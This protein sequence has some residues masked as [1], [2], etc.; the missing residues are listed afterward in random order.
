[1]G[2]AARPPAWRALAR[3]GPFRWDD[4]EPYRAARVALGVALP[5]AGGWLTGHLE[6]GAYAALGALPAG[7]A[8]FQGE[9]RTRL[10]AV[11]VASA[12]MA[13]STFVGATAAFWAPWMLVPILALWGYVTGLSESLGQ[14]FS[15]AIL[16][17]PMALLIAVGLPAPYA[18]AGLYA[19][20]V[21]A[22]GALQAGLVAV[23][24]T[25]RPGARERAM[26]AASFQGLATYA[27]RVAEGVIG[28][29]PPTAFPAGSIL[30]DPN[31]LLPSALRLD[32]VDLLE[33][34]ERIRASLAALEAHAA[35]GLPE[36]THAIGSLM[37]KAAAV[38][39]LIA[40]A[41][42]GPASGRVKAVRDINE[43]AASLV[44]AH[45]V[46][47]RWAGEALLGQLRAVGRVVTHLETLNAPSPADGARMTASPASVP[48]A[49][50]P[51]L[52]LLRANIT[53]KTETGRHAI[54]L[55]VTVALAEILALAAGLYESR[56][57]A[58]TIF[59]VLKP[60]YN[61]TLVRGVHRALGTIAGAALGVA[62]AAAAHHTLGL[63]V[64]DASVLIYLAYTLFDANYLFFS[65]FLTAFIVIILALF[66]VPAVPTAEARILNTGIGA[67]MALGAYL[68]W[69]T[70]E[71]M[72]AQEK[73]ARLIETHGL[74]VTALLRTLTDPAQRDAPALRALQATARR[75]RSDAEAAC[76]RLAGE[77]A[78]PPLTPE[79]ALALIAALAREARAALALHAFVLAESAS[80]SWAG[81]PGDTAALDRFTLARDRAMHTLAHSVRTLHAPPP[82]TALRPLYVGLRDLG[83][84]RLS[85]LL[86]IA[87]RLVNTT[88]S[89]DTILRERLPASPRA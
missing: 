45:D 56:W 60:D 46:P 23:A 59:F 14:R 70:W 81:I 77:P 58:L 25:L 21:L 65:L 33:Q 8:S 83:P 67:I 27:A 7:F 29:P 62:A 87:D 63:L 16:Q 11:A 28:P 10:A 5:L 31:P 12:G 13:I 18:Q 84:P 51:G 2:A 37:Q 35:D 1:M 73:F 4:V 78:H 86:D 26:L 57:I 38:L 71:G 42:S 72:A 89:L 3:L 85:P 52:G 54:R 44:I 80:S 30:A 15:V 6:Y 61:S 47:W 66:G 82:I 34:L 19:G 69:P 17:W 79:M 88:N 49:F 48:A 55:A 39:G 22:G 41:L 40:S 53:T 20:L 75:A 43:S 36:R 32:L 9:T 76:A 74:Y 50:A 64:L 68:V 24:W